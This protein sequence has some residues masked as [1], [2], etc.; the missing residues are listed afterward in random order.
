MRLGRYRSTKA[1]C[2]V[3]GVIAVVARSH[4]VR[5]GVFDPMTPGDGR[6]ARGSAAFRMEQVDVLPTRLPQVSPLGTKVAQRFRRS[7]SDEHRAV[8]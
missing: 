8:A 3:R 1:I 7:W 6:T 2:Q 5:G 4:C